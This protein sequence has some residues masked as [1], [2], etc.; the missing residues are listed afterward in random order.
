MKAILEFDLSKENREFRLAIDGS[1]WMTVVHDIDETLRR[2]IRY[3]E[4]LTEEQRCCY[5]K[6]REDIR[7]EMIEHGLNFDD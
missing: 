4:S 2:E 7:E 3:N 6:I 1:K 5:E